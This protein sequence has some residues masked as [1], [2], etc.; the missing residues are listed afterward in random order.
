MRSYRTKLQIAFVLLGLAAVGVT[1][2]QSSSTAAAALREATYQRL[3]AIAETKRRQ[4]ERYFKN[5]GDHVLALSS[6]ESTLRAMEGFESAWPSVPLVSAAQEKALAETYR[7][8]PP[9]WYPKDPRTKT[10]QSAFFA[11]THPEALRQLIV[12]APG[13]GAYGEIH[14]RFHPTLHRYY[15]AFGFYD[16]FLISV[17]DSRILYTVVKEIDLGMRLKE[18]P[19]DRTSLARLVQRT[20]TLQEPETYLVEDYEAYLPSRLEPAAFFAAPMW[21]GGAQI[22]VLAIQISIDELNAVMTGDENWE[23]EGL[24]KTGQAYIV[25]PDNELRSEMRF[26]GKK[27]ESGKKRILNVAIPREVAD[28]IRSGVRG[29]HLGHDF[30]NVPVLRSHTPLTISGLNWTLIAEIESD[31]ALKPVSNLQRQVLFW[32]IGLA[33]VVLA[34]ATILARS[35]TKPVLALARSASRI[36]SRDFDTKL[37]VQSNDEIGQLAASFNQMAEDLRRTTVSKGELETLAGRLIGAQEEER[38]RIARELHDDLSQRLAATAIDLG[39]LQRA[40]PEHEDDLLRVK[41]Q[42]V[43]LSEDVHGLSRRLHSS[44]LDDIGLVAAVEAECRSFF[45]RGGPPVTFSADGEF[46]FLEHD[47]QLALYRIVQEALRNIQKHSG[48]DDVSVRLRRIADRVELEIEDN[49]RGFD[50]GDRSWRRGVGLASMEERANLLQGQCAIQS[51]VGEGTRIRV[52]VPVSNGHNK[53][54]SIAG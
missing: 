6:D 54:K 50:L 48:A 7:A 37:P 44:T 41:A 13:T 45:E 11:S 16:I 14:A 33:I 23:Q 36:G 15:G 25:G 27:G 20:L 40:A 39:R 42:V 30:R 43:R 52:S 46:E 2:W 35:V 29:T 17:R 49:G 34:L 3:T 12:A 32:G 5:V 53:A 28:S 10:L 19:Y 22:G 51:N 21:R 38:T 8:L 24:G 47:V 31:E 1:G 4:V 9:E 18:A 26:N